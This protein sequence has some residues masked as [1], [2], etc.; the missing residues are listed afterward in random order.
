MVSGQVIYRSKTVSPSSFCLFSIVLA[1]NNH[2]FDKI[3]R[4]G[5]FFMFGSCLSLA[6]VWWQSSVRLVWKCSKEQPTPAR[7]AVSLRGPKVSFSLCVARPSLSFSVSRR[8][9]GAFRSL[10]HTSPTLKLSPLFLRSHS[11]ASLENEIYFRLV[12]SFLV[13]VVVL[14]DNLGLCGA[15][16]PPSK[17]DDKGL[18]FVLFWLRRRPLCR[19]W[20]VVLGLRNLGM[21]R[22]DGS[23]SVASQ[24]IGP[25]ILLL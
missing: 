18:I 10:S 19:I 6:V 14:Y 17:L 5:I 25:P 2:F 20:G 23:R 21:P 12:D 11:F 13:V 1:A 22:F 24:F 16:K 15:T 8:R 3:K 4:K 7:Q 9:E